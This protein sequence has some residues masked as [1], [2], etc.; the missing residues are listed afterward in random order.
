MYSP[1][2]VFNQLAITYRGLGTTVKLGSPRVSSDFKFLK[3]KT[4]VTDPVIQGQTNSQ[5]DAYWVAE[6]SFTNQNNDF[7]GKNVILSVTVPPSWLITGY[8][9]SDTSLMSYARLLVSAVLFFASGGLIIHSVEL[10]ETP[11]AG[12][13]RIHPNDLVKLATFVKTIAAAR[14]TIVKLIGPSLSQVDYTTNYRQVLIN[15]PQTFNYWDIHATENDKDL[16]S[17]TNSIATIETRKYMLDRLRVEKIEFE[18]TNFTLEKIASDMF[19]KIID[20]IETSY[21]LRLADNIIGAL[22]NR[23]GTLIFSN[24]HSTTGE[25]PFFNMLKSIAQKFPINGN[26]YEAEALNV[27]DTTMKTCVISPNSMSFCVMMSRPTYDLFSGN[28]TLEISNPIWSSQYSLTNLVLSSFPETVD[29]SSCTISATP[30][31]DYNSASPRPII[32]LTG[33]PYNCV[34]F[35][36]ASV[37]S[38]PPQ[39]PLPPPSVYLSETLVQV[40]MHYGTPTFFT[41]QSGNVYYDSQTNKTKVYDSTLGWINATF[42]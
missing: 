13:A 24:T 8:L 16:A 30:L 11:D 37:I 9:T 17:L 2:T 10:F 42:K 20:P 23:F 41:P 19:T 18:F 31:T 33:L 1:V 4:G 5:S 6:S 32:K 36:T 29:V 15:A 27:Q 28:L 3:L 22:A 26:I 38:T 34:L 35:L 21:A 39:P 25:R 7:L 40:P 14:N 12:P